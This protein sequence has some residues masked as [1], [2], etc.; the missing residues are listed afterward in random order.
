MYG[1]HLSVSGGMH[2]ALIDAQR[3]T[4]EAVQV[5][6]KN[7]QQWK[8]KPLEAD[9]IALW[10]ATRDESGTAQTVSHASYL[11][12]LATPDDDLWT[13]SIELFVE[14]LRRCDALDIPH[15]VIHPGAHV[16][17]GESAGLKRVA[18]ALDRAHAALPKARV[19]TCL[20][21]TAGQGSSLGHTFEHLAEIIAQTKK[22]QRLG[23]CLDT[24]HLFA[25]GYD[26]RGRKYA[27]FMKQ[28]ESTIGIDRVKVWHLNDS[29]KPLGSRLDRH[30]HIGVGTIGI[31]GFRP[32]V[33]DVRWKAVPKIL[34]TPKGQSPKGV[35]WDT[36]NVE[37]LRGLE[38]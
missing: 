38:E 36:V 22:P 26:F 14:E 17:S 11:I 15:L 12:N 35:D 5:F 3:L 30:D 2:K 8:C 37:I 19:L 16:G 33:R 29:K 27:G 10:R 25:G 21:S 20:E 24:A 4:L 1:S 28:L 9:A 32:I 6:T 13:K 34:E 7:Q 31:E 23:V 18:A